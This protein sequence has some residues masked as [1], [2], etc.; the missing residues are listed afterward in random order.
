MAPWGAN[1]VELERREMS[2][3][4]RRIAAARGNGAFAKMPQPVP[5]QFDRPDIEPR[6]LAAAAKGGQAWAPSERFLQQL[7]ASIAQATQQRNSVIEVPYSGQ[8]GRSD[9]HV[10]G[11][12]RL[13]GPFQT[14]RSMSSEVRRTKAWLE[15]Q[16]FKVFFR[17]G[18]AID[19]PPTAYWEMYAKLPRA[20]RQI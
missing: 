9:G 3:I 19:I 4:K 17:V 8:I 12:P 16:G 5:T 7:E 11:W 6:L 14:P 18:A 10:F 1:R 13:F 15:S 2:G 20:L